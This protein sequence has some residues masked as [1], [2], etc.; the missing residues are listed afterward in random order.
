MLSTE[1]TEPIVTIGV[2]PFEQFA[3]TPAV[4]EALIGGTDRPF[5]LHYV[6]CMTPERYK[7]EIMESLRALPD[8]RVRIHRE[9]RYLSPTQ[10]KN[11]IVRNAQTPYLFLI[12]NNCIAEPGYLE[13]LLEASRAYGDQAVISC[14]QLE[15]FGPDRIHHEPEFCGFTKETASGRTVRRPVFDSSVAKRIHWQSPGRVE[16]VEPHALFASTAVFRQA[17]AFDDAINTRFHYDVSFA[18]DD[19]GIPMVLQPLSRVHYEPPRELADEELEFF[20]FLT[21]A[22]WCERSNRHVREKWNCPDMMDSTIH[23]VNKRYRRSE[24]EWQMHATGSIP[25][26]HDRNPVHRP[27]IE[28]R[29]EDGGVCLKHGGKQHR[30]NETAAL[31]WRLCDGSRSA[32]EIGYLL[33]RSFDDD[34]APVLTHTTETLESFR[35]DGLIEFKENQS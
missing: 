21:D 22:D 8:S 29:E 1:S 25:W 28:T 23:I 14:L 35:N 3:R 9:N 4:I 6:D 12:E 33:K 31:I 15:G 24:E 32:R 16:T 26:F 10:C 19:A 13:P 27:G 18:I 7:R 2:V 20:S 5:R 30:L 11:I 34:S 17:G